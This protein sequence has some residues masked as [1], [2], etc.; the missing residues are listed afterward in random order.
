MNATTAI[1]TTT[2]DTDVVIVGA[3]PNGLMLA[4]E[5][6]LA[7][8]RPTVLEAL[9]KRATIPKANG[10]VG[11]AVQALH[12]RGLHQAITGGTPPPKPAPFFQF[13]ALPLDMSTMDDNALF[14]LPVPQR[15][16]EEVL[17]N[18]ADVQVRRGHQVHDLTQHDDHVTLDVTGPDG[19]YELTARYVVGADG[20]RSVVRKRADIAFPGITDEGFT[21]RSGQVVIHEPVA[22]HTTGRL[23]I[24]SLGVLWPGTF[25]RTEHGVFA[26]GMFQSGIYRVAMIEWGA[27]GLTDTD[28]MPLDEL[29]AAAKRIL[30]IDLPMSEPQDGQPPVLNRRAEGV[31]SRLADHY[32]RGRVL[33]LGDAAHVHSGI[34]G[35]GLNLGLQDA[36]NL[37]WKLAAEIN[38]W[39][40]PDLLDTYEAERRPVGHRVITQSRAQ[41]ALLAEGPN[42]TALREVLTELL[43]DEQTVR[44]ISHLMSGADTTY[45]MDTTDPGTTPH[46]LTGRW[47]PD[48]PLSDNTTVA[49]LSHTGRPLLLDFTTNPTRTDAAQPWATRID[50]HATTTP[51]PPAD[52]ILI[53]PDGYVAWAGTDPT[54]LTRAL[55]KWFGHPQNGGDHP[56]TL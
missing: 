21:H 35:P 29:R 14:I 8:I 13:G 4:N 20:G 45:D 49:E 2:V 22:D 15:R 26:F 52:A 53:R 11:R 37:G 12:Y 31:N 9:P 18:H 51:S 6:L 7:G 33:L 16:L 27:S 30:G 36:L 42:T 55:T 1:N 32:R 40:P 46:P 56:V 44:R 19:E 17:E 43:Q 39:A 54:A 41:T 10:L 3:G 28:E 47:M 23:E 48:L 5:L 50:I 34:G 38:G 25:H 24:P